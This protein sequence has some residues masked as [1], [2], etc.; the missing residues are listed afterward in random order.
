MVACNKLWFL[1]L[2]CSWCFNSHGI[3]PLHKPLK[4][5]R[6]FQQALI[7]YPQPFDLEFTDEQYL[8]KHTDTLRN[9]VMIIN[10]WTS[11]NINT[12]FE[13]KALSALQEYFFT[14]GYKIRILPI[15]IDLHKIQAI[16]EFYQQN[17]ITKLD[18]Y[19]TTA[20]LEKK[21]ILSF[22]SSVIVDK[23]GLLIAL[24]NREV[25]WNDHSIRDFLLKLSLKT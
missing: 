10:F 12:V 23:K 11:W 1:L 13:L 14:N 17:D 15:S 9:Q 25:A 3:I 2:L 20:D 24:I 16:K 18:I 6:Y 7:R 19:S 8:T 22:P 21:E 5:P 4:L